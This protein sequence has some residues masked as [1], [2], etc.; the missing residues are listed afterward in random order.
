M[1]KV[2]ESTSDTDQGCV[3]DGEMI[4]L[5]EEISLNPFELIGIWTQSSLSTVAAFFSPFYDTTHEMNKRK[6][7]NTK[8]WKSSIEFAK[9]SYRSSTIR[10]DDVII[11]Y[12]PENEYGEK[13]LYLCLPATLATLFKKA[14]STYNINVQETKLRGKPGEWWKTTYDIGNVFQVIDKNLKSTPV[15]L[16]DIMNYTK[17][18]VRA[19]LRLEFFSRAVV[20][21]PRNFDNNAEISII[22]RIL[23]GFITSIGVDIERPVPCGSIRGKPL[24]KDTASDDIIKILSQF[25]P[26]SQKENLNGTG[27]PCMSGSDSDDYSQFPPNP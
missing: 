9:G 23:A 5:E 17:K 10:I 1:S 3:S 15:S 14:G 2:C 21:G 12:S 6:S 16:I 7:P 19:N 20:E 25:K 18:G 26:R 4:S 13:H 11:P 24:P 8:Y 22:V 27:I